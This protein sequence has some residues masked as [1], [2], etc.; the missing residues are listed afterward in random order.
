MPATT[1]E[2]AALPTAAALRPARSPMKQP[3]EPIRKP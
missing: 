3:T 2:V 1:A